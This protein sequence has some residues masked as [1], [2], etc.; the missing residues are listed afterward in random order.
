MLLLLDMPGK[1]G[2]QP[3][4]SMDQQVATRH[5]PFL[6][7][8]A[9]ETVHCYDIDDETGQF[10][11]ITIKCIED[12]DGEPQACLRTWDAGGWKVMLGDRVVNEGSHPFKQCPVIPVTENGGIFP[13]IGH[14]A[15]IADLSRSIFNAASGLDEIIR[16]QTFSIPTMQVTAEQAAQFDPNKMA[17][18]LGTHNLLMYPGERPGFIAPDAQQAQVYRDVI[19][20]RQA[21]IRRVSMEEA[22]A[23][24]RTAA[25]E[26]GVARRLRFERLNAS[27]SGFARQMQSAELRQK[28]LAAPTAT[29]VMAIWQEASQPLPDKQKVATVRA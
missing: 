18:I 2:D 22:T 28:L 14:F 27:L 29:D 1:P 8:I 10:E 3:P 7:E 5:V 6:R 11:S 19:S 26:S 13:Q 12:V 15:Q 24:P 17:V 25:A 16:S 23:D 4:E 21:A 9:P 20:D